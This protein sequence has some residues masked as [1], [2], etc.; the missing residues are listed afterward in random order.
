MTL[1]PTSAP[2]P[3][4]EPQTHIPSS[5]ECLHLE[6]PLEPQPRCSQSSPPFPPTDP[7]HPS[8]RPGRLPPPPH[9][10][11]AHGRL[12]LKS[13]FHPPFFS[14]LMT[15]VLDQAI[16]VIAHQ[17]C[18]RNLPT[19]L[20]TASLSLAGQPPCWSCSDLPRML[21]YHVL[22]LLKT[23]WT[24]P[25][26]LRMNPTSLA[27]LA[28]PPRGLAPPFS[29]NYS[30]WHSFCCWAFFHA[31]LLAWSTLFTLHL[32]PCWRLLLPVS[33]SSWLSSPPGSF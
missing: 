33:D 7:T 29:P 20:P 21:S 5:A 32:P 11:S 8:W 24:L 22:F 30:A 2:I 3:C 27:R 12:S 13:S 18:R 16:I 14:I 28:G 25:T 15:T 19:G 1:N 6:M 26:A 23:L 9:L 17:A 31:V 10:V 4:P